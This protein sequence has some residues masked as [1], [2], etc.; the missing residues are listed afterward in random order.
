MSFTP[1]NNIIPFPNWNL[2]TPTLPKFYWDVDSQEERIKR[3]CLELHK[4][5]EYV[6]MLC[7]NINIDHSL[8]D[9]LQRA[10]ANIEQLDEIDAK[11]QV[12]QATADAVEELLE[13][14]PNYEEF[15]ELTSQVETLEN[16]I[17]DDEYD[18]TQRIPYPV[19]P[20]SKYGTSGQ[21][22]STNADGSTQWQNPI[23]PTDTQAETYIN[24]WLDAHPDAVTTLDDGE[25]VTRFIA[26]GA[27]T[28]AKLAQTDGVLSEVNGIQ[29]H[30]NVSKTYPFDNYGYL[31]ADTGTITNLEAGRNTGF[32]PL[33]G[34]ASITYKNNLTSAGYG[35]AF[36]DS[37]RE[38]VSSISVVGGSQRPTTVQITNEILAQ[39]SYALVSNYTAAGFTPSCSVSANENTFDYRIESL[40]DVI[41]TTLH[42]SDLTIETGINKFNPDD[43]NVGYEIYGDGSIR[44]HS[45]S[46]TSDFIPVKDKS[47]VY[48]YNLPTYSDSGVG[49]SRYSYFYDENK[50]PVGSNVPLST[51]AASATVQVPSNA[52]FY[53]F[54]IYQ[55]VSDALLPMDYSEVMVTTEPTTD[56]YIPYVA[57]VSKIKG[58]EIKGYEEGESE[59]GLKVLI[60]G[61]SITE[62]ASMNDDGSSYVEGTRHNWPEYANN[63]MHWSSFKNYAKSGAT[64]KDRG[65]GY[66]Y[67]QT[68]ANQIAIAMADSNNDDV[69][70]VVFSLG[71]NDGSSNI[72]SY[73]TAMSKTTLASLDQTYLYEALRYAYWSVRSKYKNAVCF[74]ALPIQ[75]AGYDQSPSLLEAISKMAERYGFIVIDGYGQSG[76]VRENNN[77]DA[78]GTDLYDGLHPNTN[79]QIKMAKLYSDIMQLHTHF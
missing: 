70:V 32:I 13:N 11:V 73:D 15:R 56:P 51:V 5:I 41:N 61:D 18:I 62:T 75:R 69:D 53:A 72:G 78:D 52:Y 24:A 60:F 45:D 34:L 79:G 44:E 2:F 46:A 23:V 17:G 19:A 55:R 6:E 29:S 43:A 25:V 71:T 40:E 12:L 77:V 37:A 48:L 28:D 49:S 38:L 35:I 66:D 65:S 76:I 26:D 33:A 39:A 30:A 36:F 7:D 74:A 63:F 31:S 21:V 64:Y 47:F 14:I 68:V 4:L 58:L 67:R 27:V 20:Y 57:L 1:T 9:E 16:R 3:I 50:D 8:I 54:S 59:S 42:E 22:L 10:L